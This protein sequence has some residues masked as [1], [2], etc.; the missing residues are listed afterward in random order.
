MNKEEIKEFFSNARKEIYKEENLSFQ[1]AYSRVYKDSLG[2]IFR[3]E[4]DGYTQILVI[5]GVSYTEDYKGEISVE[6]LNV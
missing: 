3:I 1:G 2:R 4:D 6:K 5:D